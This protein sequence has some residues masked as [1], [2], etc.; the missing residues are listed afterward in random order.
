MCV[1][2]AVRVEDLDEAAVK[3]V[4]AKPS[5]SSPALG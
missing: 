2:E 3:S 5:P 1:T 4:S